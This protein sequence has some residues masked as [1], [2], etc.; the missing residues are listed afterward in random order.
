MKN[1]LT[2]LRSSYAISAAAA[3][4]MRR[5]SV[6]GARLDAPSP[7]LSGPHPVSK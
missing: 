1:P 6:I 3:R 4:V 7:E 2:I 5:V